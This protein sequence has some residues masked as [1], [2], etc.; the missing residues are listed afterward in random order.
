MASKRRGDLLETLPDRLSEQRPKGEQ[1]QKILEDFVATLDPGTP[2]P[3]E[4]PLRKRLKVARG[5]VTQAIDELVAKGLVYRVERSGTY[6]AE[7]KLRQPGTLTSFSEDMRAQGMTPGSI[8]LEQEVVPAS[9]II[10]RQLE[11]EPGTP[12]VHLR[13]VRTADGEPMALERSHLPALRFPGLEAVDLT[14]TSLYETLAKR[15]G[16]QVASAEQWFSAVRPTEAEAA[17]LGITPDQPAL[18]FQ[19]VTRDPAGQVIEFARS[20]Y[21]GDRYEVHAQL[22]RPDSAPPAGDWNKQIR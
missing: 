5:T 20:L 9:L 11:V 6:V 7:R 12:V 17:H 8:V 10:A 2:L 19:R 3:G 14:D 16:V 4:E 1:V 13:R 15:W 21:R 18:L 22:R